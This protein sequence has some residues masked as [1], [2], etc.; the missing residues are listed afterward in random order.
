MVFLDEEGEVVDLEPSRNPYNGVKMILL[1]IT[2]LDRIRSVKLTTEMSVTNEASQGNESSVP[3]LEPLYK[4][5]A[6]LK[7]KIVE[8][9]PAPYE[10][11][12]ETNYKLISLW[13][14]FGIIKTKN[15]KK[16]VAVFGDR[17]ELKKLLYLDGYNVEMEKWV[18]TKPSDS[19]I[20]TVFGDALDGGTD[21]GFGRYNRYIK[22]FTEIFLHKERRSRSS[23][24]GE[25]I[26]I[27][28][29]IVLQ[30]IKTKLNNPK[31]L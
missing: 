24:F 31:G 13:E 20:T 1:N 25:D 6:S 2:R 9:N 3:I 8:G 14:R 29:P 21:P 15:D 11:F 5:Y 23:S 18:G 4:L 30:D 26:G 22:E 17:N 19:S 16:S 28:D 12:E 7:D 27:D 10:F